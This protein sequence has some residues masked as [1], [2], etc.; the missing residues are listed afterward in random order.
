MGG[1]TAWQQGGEGLKKHRFFI[2][3]DYY[4]AQIN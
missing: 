3:N 4:K 1:V 2:T